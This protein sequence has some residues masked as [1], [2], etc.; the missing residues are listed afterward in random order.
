MF[1]AILLLGAIYTGALVGTLPRWPRATWLIPFAWLLLGLSRIR[2]APLFGISAVVALAAVLP[3]SRLA[4]WLARPGRDLFQRPAEPAVWFDWRPALLPLVLVGGAVMMQVANV[5]AP[6][7]GRGWAGLDPTV[8]PVELL[9]ALRE[10]EREHPNGARVLNDYTLGGYLIYHTPRLKVFIDDRCELYG[11]AWLEDYD[12][13]SMT[14]PALM[15]GWLAR[16]AIDYVLVAPGSP[17][18]THISTQPGWSIQG[19]CPVANF[20]GRDS[21]VMKVNST[22]G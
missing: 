15:D 18:D 1:W 13:A 3:H 6:V 7:V 2:H 22:K 10:A 17:F 20:Y 16:Y 5:R 11:D 21:R 14:D 12:R 19:R 4:V 8:W 9:P